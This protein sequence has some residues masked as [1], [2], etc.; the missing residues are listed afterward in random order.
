MKKVT[1]PEGVLDYVNEYETVHLKKPDGSWAYY[2]YAQYNDDEL[3]FIELS[4]NCYHLNSN[5]ITVA[6][7]EDNR[8]H[9][10]TKNGESWEITALVHSDVSEE[11]LFP[12]ENENPGELDDDDYYRLMMKRSR[13]IE[14]YINKRLNVDDDAKVKIACS[15][16]TWLE[17][18]DY[19]PQS[20]SSFEEHLSLYYNFDY[21][22]HIIN[23]NPAKP[24]TW[25]ENIFV[26]LNATNED[27]FTWFTKSLIAKHLPADLHDTWYSWDSEYGKYD[28]D[29]E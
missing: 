27:A 5:D 10:H 18:H 14:Q 28:D 8:I 2:I 26:P 23:G 4:N 6:Y 11:L 7:M 15:L 19:I 13:V 20:N 24:A 25:I 17:I 29:E 1:I 3:T 21:R 22:L 9:L 16:N 12:P